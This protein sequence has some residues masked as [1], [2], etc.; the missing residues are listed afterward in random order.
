MRL[1]KIYWRALSHA[2]V[3]IAVSHRC[4]HVQ[5]GAIWIDCGQ[6]YTQMFFFCINLLILLIRILPL[7][8]HLHPAAWG[9]IHLQNQN[10]TIVKQLLHPLIAS[11][12]THERECGICHRRCMN[13]LKHI[14]NHNGEAPFWYANSIHYNHVGIYVA[15]KC[16][17]QPKKKMYRKKE[18]KIWFVQC[19]YRIFRLLE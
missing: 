10:Y 15:A 17:Q 14:R 12:A 2:I 3:W 5:K 1:V 7:V 4:V 9:A 16:E 18:K 13:I 11:M 8:Q 19:D 6:W